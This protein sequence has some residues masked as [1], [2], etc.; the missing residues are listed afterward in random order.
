MNQIYSIEN[1]EKVEIINR[2]VVVGFN[3][4]EVHFKT[5]ANAFEKY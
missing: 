2:I 4:P 1:L 5:L 3:E